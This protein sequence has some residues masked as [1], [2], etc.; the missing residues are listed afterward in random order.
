M[1]Q[2]DR[3]LLA[4]IVLSI[5]SLATTNSIKPRFEDGSKLV[6]LV[7]YGISYVPFS[8]EGITIIIIKVVF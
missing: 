5:I 7:N 3:F 8:G 1:Y 6:Y 4:V 2:V